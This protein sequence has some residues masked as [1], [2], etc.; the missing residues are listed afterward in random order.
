MLSGLLW[1][2]VGFTMGAG[3]GFG[4]ARQG[5]SPFDPVTRWTAIG[6][7]LCVELIWDVVT[8]HVL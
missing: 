5:L 7:M 1:D 4:M 3:L 6:A 8:G 2:V